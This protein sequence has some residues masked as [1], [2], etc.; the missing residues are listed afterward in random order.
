MLRFRLKELLAEKELREERRISWGMMS[1]ETGV[2]V[3]VLSSLGS[4]HRQIVT[5][6]RYLE[7]IC[8]FLECSLDELVLFVP[9][10][11]EE[12]SCH[13]DRLYQD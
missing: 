10:R 11:G 2:G 9:E 3:G 7:A 13:V 1:Q 4:P 12:E 8:R 5:N 6:T